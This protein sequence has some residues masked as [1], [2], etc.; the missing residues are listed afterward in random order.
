MKTK[1]TEGK[2]KT[3]KRKGKKRKTPLFV[4]PFSCDNYIYNFNYTV[5]PETHSD[6]I[7]QAQKIEFESCK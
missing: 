6:L 2:K 7:P 1:R 5:P 4:F 3:G